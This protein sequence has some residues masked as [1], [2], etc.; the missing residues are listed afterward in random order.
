MVITAIAL[1]RYQLRH[2][3]LPSDLNALVP[4]FLSAVPRDPVDGKPLRYRLNPDGTFLLYSVGSDGMDNGGD[5]TPS[6]SS[7]TFYWQRGRD[8]VWP[9][10]ATAQ[11]VQD[12]Y[13]NLP[14]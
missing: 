7:K 11:E 14:K 2:G 5:P 9:Q 3:A 12:Y 6:G 10:P 4:E 13:D 8:W 1:K